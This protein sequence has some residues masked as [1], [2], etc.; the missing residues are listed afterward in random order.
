MEYIAH[1]GLSDEAPENTAAAFRLAHDRGFQWCELD[2]NVSADDIPVVWHDDKL[3]PFGHSVIV[4]KTPWSELRTLDMGSWFNHRFSDQLL[5]SLQEALDL[6]RDLGMAVNVELKPEL[7]E[8]L[9][10]TFSIKLANMLNTAA[11]QNHLLLSSFHPTML[12]WCHQRC[13]DIP[14]ALLVEGR[15]LPAHQQLA[16]LTEAEA[17]HL[18]DDH[19]ELS[20]LNRLRDAGWTPRVYT[21]NSARRARQLATAGCA[22]IF[23]DSLYPEEAG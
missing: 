10:D 3:K 13:P 23:T 19:L 16:E 4:S 18:D 20:S 7:A 11:E 1:R 22:G 2:V 9:S 21:V 12:N 17:L 5:M 8:R 15:L 14:R 6:I